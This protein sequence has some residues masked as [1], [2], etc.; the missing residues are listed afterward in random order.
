MKNPEKLQKAF[1]FSN[2]KSLAVSN[3]NITDLRSVWKEKFFVENRE[4]I[5]KV[6]YANRPA[7][8][9]KVLLGSTPIFDT[10]SQPKISS[11]DGLKAPARLSIGRFTA[12][13][14]TNATMLSKLRKQNM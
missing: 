5:L 10:W 14:G 13:F 12:L 11:F 1:L 8:H 7:C 4:F 6:D 2:W 3:M 9:K